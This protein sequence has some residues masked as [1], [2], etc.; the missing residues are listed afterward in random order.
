MATQEWM[1]QDLRQM[2]IQQIEDT[3]KN[4][5]NP[6]G[7]T[8]HELE[9]SIMEKAQSRDDYIRMAAHL[10]LGI[11]E[12]TNSQMVTTNSNNQLVQQQMQ[13]QTLRPNSIMVPVMTQQVL[14]NVQENPSSQVLN[15]INGHGQA[16]QVTLQGGQIINQQVGQNFQMQQQRQIQQQT[17]LNTL[18]MIVTSSV[19][20]VSSQQGLHASQQEIPQQHFQLVSHHQL[21]Q[22]QQTQQHQIQ[23]SQQTQQLQLQQSQQTQQLQL[24]QSQQTQQLQLQQTQPTQLSQQQLQQLHQIQMH[25]KQ[26][27]HQQQQKM[28]QQQMQQLQMQQIQHQQQIHQQQLQNLQS[29]VSS[30]TNNFLP[31]AKATTFMPIQHQKQPHPSPSNVIFVSSPQQ[32]THQQPSPSPAL[33]S[34]PSP[35]FTNPPSVGPATSPPQQADDQTYIE[36]LKELSKYVTPLTETLAMMQKGEEHKKGRDKMAGLLDVI[37]NKN[38]RV[39]ADMLHKCGFALKRLF[40]EADTTSSQIPDTTT[41]ESIPTPVAKLPSTFPIKEVVTTMIT[42]A[43]LMSEARQNIMPGIIALNTPMICPPP[44]FKRSCKRYQQKRKSLLPHSLQMEVAKLQQFFQ[45]RLDSTQT[46]DSAGVTLICRL[47]NSRDNICIFIRVSS[48]YPHEEPSFYVMDSDS[49]KASRTQNNTQ[50]K[51][52][53]L[54]NKRTFSAILYSWEKSMEET[55]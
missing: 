18:N 31:P 33:Q 50:L 11:K 23:Q 3:Y 40:P 29:G 48:N 17:N 27:Q 4:F 37:T 36:K 38:R 22:P 20:N 15:Q 54:I 7:K 13:N 14:Q 26:Q 45:I 52:S 42:S 30:Q 28:Q 6:I 49:T 47:K 46:A 55:C 51:L 41:V 9:V 19:P 44:L 2:I 53:R 5:G 35:A 34:A 39:S 12:M 25:K 21:Q 32:A 43:H 10:I 24:Q 1:S 16:L 8:S